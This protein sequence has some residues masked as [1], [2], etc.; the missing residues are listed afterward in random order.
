MDGGCIEGK[1]SC[2][3]DTRLARSE[4]LGRPAGLEMRGYSGYPRGAPSCPDEDLR[5]YRRCL[6][7]CHKQGYTLA[8][9]RPKTLNVCVGSNNDFEILPII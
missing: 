3:N 4:S 7:P 8:Y 1:D 2:V 5:I 6:F 9:I